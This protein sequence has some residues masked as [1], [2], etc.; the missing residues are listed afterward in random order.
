MTEAA[1]ASV[2]VTCR[3]D[4][5]PE[6]VFDAFLDVSIAPRFMSPQRPAR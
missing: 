5:A 6:R 4:A 1:F 2:T 3:Y